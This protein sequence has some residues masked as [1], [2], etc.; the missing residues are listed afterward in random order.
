[1]L[2]PGDLLYLPPRWAHDGIAVGEC[3]TASVGFR[4]PTQGGLARELLQRIADG[5]DD[6]GA[7][8]RDPKQPATATPGALPPAL[9][10]FAR[11]SLE[12]VLCEPGALERALG[13]VLTE[14]KPR[15]WFDG[16]AAAGAG[17]RLDA[18]TRMLYDDRRVFINGEAFDAAGRD[19]RLM[20]R[21]ADTR[22]L[23]V[24]D[25]AALSDGARALL[26]E[27]IDAGW[28]HRSTP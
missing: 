26:D 21:L 4:V 22:R 25:G 9:V 11:A 5:V 24:R 23:D 14:P 8:Y 27:W 12:R 16:G 20:R 3:M 2:D 18:K 13:E 6:D 7:L 15:V 19:A 28:L 10:D 1:M 17:L